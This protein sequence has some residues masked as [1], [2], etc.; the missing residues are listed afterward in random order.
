M[1]NALELELIRVWHE[2]FPVAL[3]EAPYNIH[4]AQIYI[5]KKRQQQVSLPPLFYY[6]FPNNA[7]EREKIDICL[8]TAILRDLNKA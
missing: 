3:T 7:F 8:K 1:L 6:F 5:N 4:A 2:A